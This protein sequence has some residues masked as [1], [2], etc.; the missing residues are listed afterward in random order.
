MLVFLLSFILVFSKGKSNLSAFLHKLFVRARTD[1]RANV[2]KLFAPFV[3]RGTSSD[4]ITVSSHVRVPTPRLN[5]TAG[6]APLTCGRARGRH[7][8]EGSRENRNP[9]HKPAALHPPEAQ[10]G[11]GCAPRHWRRCGR[12]RQRGERARTHRRVR[13]S[14][15][16]IGVKQLLEIPPV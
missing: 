3:Y 13:S 8:G 2:K 11:D 9:L 4:V 7:D 16:G 14:A 6:S 12:A 1:L 10:D 15:P 5:Q